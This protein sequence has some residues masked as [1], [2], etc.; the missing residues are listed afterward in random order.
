MTPVC[1]TSPT[2]FNWSFISDFKFSRT[3]CQ[4]G[5]FFQIRQRTVAIAQLITYFG[6]FVFGFLSLGLRDFLY[7]VFCLQGKMGKT[8]WKINK[9]LHNTLVTSSP[10]T[11]KNEVTKMGWNAQMRQKWFFFEAVL[12][13]IY[14]I[15]IAVVG[16][17][18]NRMWI[19]DV[20]LPK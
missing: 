6:N 5:L 4:K 20:C 3:I 19:V 11:T 15:H 8:K 16:E 9:L 7:D 18:S 12:H 2:L 13:R 14:N 17:I 10:K 1:K